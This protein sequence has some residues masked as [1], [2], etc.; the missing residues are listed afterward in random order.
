MSC[1][2][3]NLVSPLLNGLNNLLDNGSLGNLSH[4]G[5]SISTGFWESKTGMSDS[6]GS[7][8]SKWSNWGSM[9]KTSIGSWG[10][11]VGSIWV[12]GSK[13]SVAGITSIAQVVG[14]SKLGFSGHRGD[15]TGKN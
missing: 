10:N 11:F 9:G 2:I 5:K 1:L 7:G 13:T 12:R 15:S 6:N 14:I 8:I 3:S 4:W